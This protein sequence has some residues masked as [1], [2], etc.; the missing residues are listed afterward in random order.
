MRSVLTR[1]VAIAAVLIVG[2]VFPAGQTRAADS[3]SGYFK[4]VPG[5]NGPGYIKST[6]SGKQSSWMDWLKQK[7]KTS[8]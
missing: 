8:N 1:S 2:G 4:P 5:K 6:S 7:I 3:Q